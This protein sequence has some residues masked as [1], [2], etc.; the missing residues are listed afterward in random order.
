[1]VDAVRSQLSVDVR[2]E[3]PDFGLDVDFTL[4]TGGVTGLFGPSGSGKST[5]LRVIAGLEKAASG[6]VRFGD[7]AW[8]DEAGAAF[9]PAHDRAVGFVFQDAQLFPH[10]SVA[11]NL[12]FAVARAARRATSIDEDEV[13]AA[14]DLEPLLGRDVAT[15]SGG[16]QQ[17]VAIGRALLSQ[18]RIMLLDEPLAALDASRKRDILPYIEALP[19][20][21]GIPA[22]YVSHAAAEMARL[23]DRVLILEHGRLTAD[24]PVRSILSREDLQ[25]SDLAFEAVTILDV[26]VIEH[27]AD[28]GLTRVR[29][30]DCDLTAP[31]I[32]GIVPGES[33]RL[34]VRAGDV[35][36]ATSEPRNLSVRNVIRGTVR[37]I[38]TQS[39]SAFAMVSVDVGT[40][41][42][43]A[44]LTRDAVAELALA[45]GR[46]VFALI[47]T[48]AFERNG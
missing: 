9:V 25:E 39:A 31:Q 14:L 5:L 32:H 6:T 43:Q 29:F 45:P 10:L 3:R 33:G 27:L 4:D 11:G 23:A 12:R 46:E 24:G 16:E 18:P 8:Q 35:V 47:K 21:F 13:V 15:L 42:L 36:I 1:M 48:A 26:E 17:R 37:D 2:L 44:R 30:R 19:R 34:L 40:T 7:T 41:A 22:V 38:R 28:L 20:R